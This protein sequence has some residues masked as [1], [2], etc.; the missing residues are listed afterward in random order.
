MKILAA[1]DGSLESE[2]VTQE[3]L[4][5]PKSDITVVNVVDITLYNA[6]IPENAERVAYNA[7]ED[8]I[9]R[10][11]DKHNVDYRIEFGYPKTIIASDLPNELDV[12]LIVLS[13][14]GMNAFEKI[15]M[16][17]T[18]NYVAT[19]ADKSVLIVA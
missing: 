12:D 10:L 4:K 7:I 8:Q 19:H 6:Q 13:K 9:K 2:K 14:T 11:Q 1:I 5:F 17:S 16:G 15:F 3:L 18:A